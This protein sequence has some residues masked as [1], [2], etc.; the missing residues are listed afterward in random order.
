MDATEESLLE[1]L[2]VWLASAA[3][4][5]VDATD[6]SLA[7]PESGKPLGPVC[8][9]P[10]PVSRVPSTILSS[11]QPGPVVNKATQISRKNSW[12]MYR[13]KSLNMT[14]RGSSTL[15]MRS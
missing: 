6:E 8:F 3:E 2:C 5:S 7:L 12:L 4:A 13:E 15:P 11:S 1:L 9:P 14:R 10:V